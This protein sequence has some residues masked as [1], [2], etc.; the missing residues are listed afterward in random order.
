[1]LRLFTPAGL[2]ELRTAA[3]ALPERQRPRRSTISGRVRHLPRHRGPGDRLPAG[4]RPHAGPP[5]QHPQLP[6]RRRALRR[7]GHYPAEEGGDPL[8][9]AF[10]ALGLQDRARHLATLYLND[11]ADVLR[12]AVDPRFE[13]VRYA[14]KLATAQPHFDPLAEA[15]AAPPTCWTAPWPR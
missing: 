14:E 4:A 3:Q 11:L 9:W 8:A 15:L 7:A 13:F 6:A 1:V 5:H 12:E 10:G 2:D